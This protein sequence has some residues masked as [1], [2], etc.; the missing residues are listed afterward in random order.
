[1]KKVINSMVP[2]EGDSW[3]GKKIA[4]FQTT[5]ADGTTG[6]MKVWEGTETPKVGDEVTLKP[7]EYMGTT[8]YTVVKDMGAATGGGGGFGKKV[9]NEH[10]E[11]AILSTGVLKSMCEAGLITKNEVIQWAWKLQNL[12]LAP[13]GGEPMKMP[14]AD[15]PQATDHILD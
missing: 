9:K 12:Y 10:L 11:A 1:M 13:G 7:R 15:Q 2:V 5:W 6:I 14:N 4:Q 8:T 3:Q